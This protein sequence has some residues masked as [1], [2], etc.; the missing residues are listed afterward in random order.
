MMTDLERYDGLDRRD[1]EILMEKG[2][3]VAAEGL[4]CHLIDQAHAD[5]ALHEFHLYSSRSTVRQRA[6]KWEEALGDLDTAESVL[7]KLPAFVQGLSRKSILHARANIH[8]NGYFAKRDPAVARTLLEALRETSE[9]EFTALDLRSRLESLV[10]NWHA[11][12]TLQACWTSLAAGLL[13][14]A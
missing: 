12:A 13:L 11:S 9:V 5:D 6:G 3:L 4:L 8:A 14:Q 10:G 1:A 7:A 2:E